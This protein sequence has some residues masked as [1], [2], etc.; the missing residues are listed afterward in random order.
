MVENTENHSEGHVHDP[1]NDGHL[2]LVG[3]QEGQPIHRHVPNLLKYCEAE[4]YISTTVGNSESKSRDGTGA[5][6]DSRGR[7]QTGRAR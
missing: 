7:C 6:G 4:T 3:V 2:H 5:D 1:N